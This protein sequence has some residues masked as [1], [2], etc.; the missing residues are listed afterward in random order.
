MRP[1]PSEVKVIPTLQLVIRRSI[2]LLFDTL[3][4]ETTSSPIT[5]VLN[6]TAGLKP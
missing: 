4:E 2:G 3:P 6:W 5:V 1:S